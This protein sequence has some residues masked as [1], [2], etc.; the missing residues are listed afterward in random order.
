MFID[1]NG[2]FFGKVSIIDVLVFA[3]IIV[4]ALGVYYKFG[5]KI[6]LANTGRVQFE[7]TVK[8]TDVRE[9]T[10]EALERKGEVFARGAKIGDIIRVESMPA[11]K[12]MPKADGVIVNAPIAERFDVLVTIK[13]D[14]K[15]GTAGYYNAINDNIYVNGEH[16]FQSKWAMTKGIITRVTA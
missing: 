5:A 12:T 4:L 14:G 8:V 13:C 1:K 6:G 3:A 7:Y 10:V 16:E 2:K 15:A 9:F 11:T